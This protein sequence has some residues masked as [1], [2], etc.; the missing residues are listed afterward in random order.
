MRIEI[1]FA[2]LT[3]FMPIVADV[4]R[5]R[6][7]FAIAMK[8]RTTYLAFAAAG[9]LSASAQSDSLLRITFKPPVVESAMLRPQFAA[10]MPNIVAPSLSNYSPPEPLQ[11]FD[12]HSMLPDSLKSA[13]ELSIAPQ[14]Y[15]SENEFDFR[16]NPFSRDW[17]AGGEIVR[18]APNLSVV[19]SGSRTSYPGLGNIATGSIGFQA[20]ATDR[21]TI[22]LGANAVKYHMGR[23]AWNDYGFYLQGSY[24]ITDRLSIDAFGQYYFDKRYHSVAG[25]GLMQSAVYG[26]SMNYRFSDTF[27]LA[28]GAQRYY[29]AYTRTWKTVPIVAPTFRLFGAPVSVDVGGLLYNIVEAIIDN[30][31]SYNYCVPSGAS[32]PVP[33][34]PGGHF[35]S[36]RAQGGTIK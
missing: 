3:F 10:I 35:K 11:I 18:L 20:N 33:V 2:G 17:S 14:V 15:P 8:M 27:S 30:A 7:K 16:A 21:L 5:K 12:R 6:R 25:M 9:A 34:S 13:P 26:G 31:R 36:H 32:A 19:G 4:W 23:S 29:D 1:L 28:L 22:G 24:Q